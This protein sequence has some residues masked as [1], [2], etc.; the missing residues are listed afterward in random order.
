M[1]APGI[2]RP[3][4]TYALFGIVPLCVGLVLLLTAEKK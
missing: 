1:A 4:A 2:H 3:G